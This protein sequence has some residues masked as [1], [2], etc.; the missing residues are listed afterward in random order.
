MNEDFLAFN[1]DLAQNYKSESQR[2]RI[3]SEKW[4]EQYGSCPLCGGPLTKYQ[5]NKPVADFFCTHCKEDF[6]LKTKKKSFGLKTSGGA[7]SK[8]IERL[9]SD[10]VPHFF[11]LVY[12]DYRVK[13]LFCVPKYFFT[14]TLVEKRKPL[15]AN[16]QRSGWTG[17]NILTNKIPNSGK[18]F[19]IKNR[20]CFSIKD[21][22][23][24]YQNT[25]F[26][27]EQK[28]CSKGWLL[29][30]MLCIDK[31]NKKEFCL[32]DLYQFESL[33]QIK[34]PK[35]CH[36]KDKIRQQLQFLRN[37]NYIEFKGSGTYKLL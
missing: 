11:F 20:Q 15:S 31:L 35:N 23:T 14:E 37:K 26:L 8:M 3:L 27:K 33:L 32:N 25:V 30:I 34:H 13:D 10:R 7:Y 5:N 16:A 24:N 36:I 9:K 21:I 29:D 17:C 18:I 19:Y 2:I 12:Q 22:I 4:L 28:Q 1:V 6:E